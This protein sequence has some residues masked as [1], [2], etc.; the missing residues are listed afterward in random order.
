MLCDAASVVHPDH[1]KSGLKDGD[2][3]PQ[4]HI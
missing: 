1:E 2:D 3:A 4:T